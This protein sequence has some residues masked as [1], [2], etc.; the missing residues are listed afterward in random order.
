MSQHWFT[1]KVIL[2]ECKNRYA[3]R[4]SYKVSNNV[5]IVKKEKRMT[6]G[7][8]Q[9]KTDIRRLLFTGR[10]QKRSTKYTLA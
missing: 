8:A 5:G 6:N 2:A 9:N 1:F 10:S 3:L 4:H 7:L